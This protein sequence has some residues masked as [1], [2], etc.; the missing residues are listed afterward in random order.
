[1]KGKYKRRST[2]CFTCDASIVEVGKKCKV[3]GARMVGAK[4]RSKTTKEYLDDS[5]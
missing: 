4:D 1:M 2:Y 5:I 3:C